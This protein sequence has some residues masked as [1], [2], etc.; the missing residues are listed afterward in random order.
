VARVGGSSGENGRVDVNVSLPTPVSPDELF[1]AVESLDRYPAWLEI[2]GRVEPADPMAG[3]AGPA[4]L[5]D[6][7]GQLGPLRRS[8]RLRMV[9]FV[10]NPPHRV[11]FTRRELDGKAH[12]RWT[13]TVDVRDISRSDGDGHTT[14]RSRSDVDGRD[15]ADGAAGT[16]GGERSGPGGGS[17]L[18]M[19]L[20]YGGGLWVPLLDRVL[21]DEIER[22]KPRLLELLGER[23]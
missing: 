14:D 19:G 17:R 3:D 12:S 23:R 4:W 5:V 7:R 10:H 1:A 18:D 22:S 6:L 8:K 11:Q 9:R 15:D 21:A 13:L 16:A 20:H 2:V